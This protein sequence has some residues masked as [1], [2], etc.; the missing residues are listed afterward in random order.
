MPEA[1][2]DGRVTYTFGAGLPT[3]VTSP[4]HISI[5]ELEPGETLTTEPAIGDSVRWELLPGTSGKG[6]ALQSL[7]M[8]KPH[9]SG[10]D[11][12]LVVTTDKRTYYL[13]LI[14]R[15]TDYMARIGFSYKA[16]ED[17]RWTRFV[18][19]QQRAKADREN[20]QVVTPMVGDAI[21]RLNFDYDI[22][23]GNTVVRPL[24]CELHKGPTSASGRVKCELRLRTDGQSGMKV[25]I[26]GDNFGASAGTV[27]INNVAAT[28]QAWSNT[29]V[30]FTVP[31]V[32]NGVYQTQLKSSSGVAANP[33]QF[34]VLAAKLIPVTF[35]VNNATPTSR[36]D[37]IF[38]TG[39][40]VE[41][42][43]WA[44]P[45]TQP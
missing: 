29:S 43:Q 6:T 44:P 17:A 24:Q 20:A 34:T 10:L 31:N 13:R 26:A 8:V 1:G 32:A 40:T 30:T 9:V 39:N 2:K 35:T 18:A 5:V 21:D 38:L 3:V 11:T 25:T 14:S 4:M 27:A 7:I 37:Y 22:K 33:I 23:G 16:N 41:L 28:I 12:N 45:S 42:G 19:E 15:E 36:R